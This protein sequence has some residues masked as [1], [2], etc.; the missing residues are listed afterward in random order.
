MSPPPPPNAP[1]PPL[2]RYNTVA[3]RGGFPGLTRGRLR[4]VLLGKVSTHTGATTPSLIGAP[5][6]TAAMVARAKV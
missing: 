6:A 4:V 5:T 2:C 1:P 3:W